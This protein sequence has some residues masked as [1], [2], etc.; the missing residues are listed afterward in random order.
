MELHRM[1]TNTTLTKLALCLAL[2]AALVLAHGGLEHV[3]G[4][5]AKIADTSVSV[6][7]ADG[8][9]VDVLVDAKTTY[10]RN[11][12]AIKKA[13]LKLGEKVVIHAEKSGTE[14]TGF[15]LTAKTV[16]TGTVAATTAPSH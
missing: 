6:T 5:I 7:G 10:A 2:C 9:T 11:G 14:K 8:K 12:K 4:T 16:E 1:N 3:M 15:K 13:D